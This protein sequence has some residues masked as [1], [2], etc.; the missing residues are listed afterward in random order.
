MA[1]A[2]LDSKFFDSKIT[3]Q[4]I[5]TAERLLGFCIGP[6]SVM[7]MNSILTSYLNVYYTDVVKLGSIWNGWKSEAKRS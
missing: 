1:K 3:T 6:V 2:H 4:S 7:L 5:G